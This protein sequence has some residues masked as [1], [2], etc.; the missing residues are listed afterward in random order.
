MSNPDPS[1]DKEQEKAAEKPCAQ[2]VAMRTIA[3]EQLRKFLSDRRNRLQE[4]RR[5]LLCSAAQLKD[6]IA[7]IDATLEELTIG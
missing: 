7:A 5:T 6:E 3:P 2:T 1:Q 4:T